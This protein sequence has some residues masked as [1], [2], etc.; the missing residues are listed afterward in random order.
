MRIISGT[1]KGQK[2]IYMEARYHAEH[3]LN[4]MMI[5]AI[6]LAAMAT[7]LSEVLDCGDSGRTILAIVNAVIALML[8]IINYL[9]L[10]IEI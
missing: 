3:Q 9:K 6:A 10:E 5:P 2:I 7:V 1:S 8:S 4:Y